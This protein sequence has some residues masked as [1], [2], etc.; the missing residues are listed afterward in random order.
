MAKQTAD[1]NCRTTTPG[2]KSAPAARAEVATSQ[3]DAPTRQLVAPAI[4]IDAPTG[5]IVVFTARID[6]P[7]I[8]FDVKTQTFDELS[9]KIDAPTIQIDVFTLQIDAPTL[10]FDAEGQF[11]L[12]EGLFEVVNGFCEQLPRVKDLLG[13]PGLSLPIL[14]AETLK[15]ATRFRRELSPNVTHGTAPFR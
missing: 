13:V 5:K 12:A 11:W 6:A 4:Q 10:I 7:I 14:V 2:W 15:V 9:I 3:L 8:D 1:Q